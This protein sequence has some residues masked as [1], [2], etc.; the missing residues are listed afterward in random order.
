LTTPPVNAR[1]LTRRHFI[2]DRPFVVDTNGA[3]TEMIIATG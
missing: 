2:D 1:K 3:E